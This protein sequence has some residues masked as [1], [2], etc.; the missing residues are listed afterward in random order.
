MNMIGN[1]ER[2]KLSALIHPL[3]LETNFL[4]T[5]PPQP[6]IQD[7]APRTETKSLDHHGL[8]PISHNPS[9]KSS[10]YSKIQFQDEKKKTEEKKKKKKKQTSESL[11]SLSRSNHEPNVCFLH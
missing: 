3:T 6:E 4:N 5:T 11:W 8:K 10:P 2:C 9:Q 7:E 1:G